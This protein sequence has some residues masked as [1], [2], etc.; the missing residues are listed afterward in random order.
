VER[1]DVADMEAGSWIKWILITTNNKK[2]I[3]E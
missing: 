2:L 3:A 1:V